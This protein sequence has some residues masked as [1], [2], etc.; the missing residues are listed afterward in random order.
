MFAGWPKDVPVEQEPAQ[1]LQDKVQE[2]CALE[3]RESVA[4]SLPDCKS[5][6]IISTETAR[7]GIDLDWF[8]EDHIFGNGVTCALFYSVGSEPIQLTW[9][10]TPRDSKGLSSDIRRSIES[11]ISSK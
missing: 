8:G 10:V 4:E 2:I 6:L 7:L 11:L 3:L 1:F 9:I 5:R